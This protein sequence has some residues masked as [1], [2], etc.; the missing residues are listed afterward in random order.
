[1]S[2]PASPRILP[3]T[4]EAIA[5]AAKALRAG[6]LVAFPTETVYGLGADATDDRAVAAVFAAKDRPRFN[7]LIVHVPGAA[8]ARTLA[9]F[10]P[11]AEALAAA[12]WP[13]PLTLVL[14]RAH[15]CPVSRLVSAG[16]ETI[17]VRV[18]DHG[19]ARA[20]LKACARPIAAPSANPSGRASPTTAAH[21]AALLDDRVDLILD[22]GPCRVGLESTVLDLCGAIPRVLR[23]G[24]IGP[25]DIARRLGERV[26]D[27][28]QEAADDDEERLSPGLSRRHY[29]PTVPLR[30][31]AA[32]VR[33]GEALLAFGPE[34]PKAPG[35]T[36]LNLSL[37][38]DVVEAAANLFAMLHALDESGAAA[39]AVMPIPERGLGRA[40][41]DRLRR[42]VAR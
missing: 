9:T 14:P 8:A 40:I 39:I 42:A 29:A 26:A 6:R 34:V 18:P 35:A 4:G 28:S 17:A 15:D 38:G 24:A 36:V 21:V 32:E 22:G 19:I 7:P 1:M 5:E 2:L 27:A 20:L 23:L 37:S 13:G 30:R 41:N 25:E 16:L 12:F 11:R 10:D 33:P 31:N 3:A